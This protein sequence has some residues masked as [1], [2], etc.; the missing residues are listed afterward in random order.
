MPHSTPS[1][2]LWK[3]AGHP[4]RPIDEVIQWNCPRLG[5]VNAV[6]GCDCSSSCICQNPEVRS[7]VE[8]IVQLALTMSPM[9]S[10]I[11]FMEYLSICK[12]RLSCH[13]SWTILRPWPCFFGTQKM[14]EFLADHDRVK[15]PSFNHSSSV[16]LMN[17]LCSSGSLNCFQ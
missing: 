8:N 5:I 12:W 3:L 14:G 16:F 4:S 9:H 7:K 15:M 1:M 6:S 13:K 2:S 11:S 10:L 17:R